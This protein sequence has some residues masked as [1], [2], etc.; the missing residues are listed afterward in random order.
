ML[1]AL[2]RHMAKGASWTRPRGGLFLWVRFPE[3]VDARVLLERAL[4]R[5]VAFVPGAA[6]FF[7]ERGRNCARLS[8]SLPD[9]QAIADG[10]A[11]LAALL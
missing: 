9:E 11:R 3:H 2:A 4:A 5:G 8:F 1:L 7:D 10:I 6:F